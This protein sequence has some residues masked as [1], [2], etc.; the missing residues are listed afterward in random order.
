LR[1]Q[2]QQVDARVQQVGEELGQYREKCFQLEAEV[3]RRIEEREGIENE[4]RKV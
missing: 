3:A 1:R 4:M 2:L